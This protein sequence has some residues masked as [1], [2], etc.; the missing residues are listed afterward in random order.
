MTGRPATD[1]KC[2]AMI[3]EFWN[4]KEAYEYA[5][6]RDPV[7]IRKAR[8]RMYKAAVF[9]AGGV[10][11][12]PYYGRVPTLDELDERRRYEGRNSTD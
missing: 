1:V 9:I 3:A 2:Y 7:G 8:T 6:T 10:D 5:S 11:L 4:A 12:E